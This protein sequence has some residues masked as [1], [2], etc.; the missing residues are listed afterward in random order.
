M[1]VFAA[2][3]AAMAGRMRREISPTPPASAAIAIVITVLAHVALGFLFIGG[4]DEVGRML[5]SAG[6][7]LLAAPCALLCSAAAF[8]GMHFTLRRRFGG[9]R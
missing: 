2:A 3:M 7:M 9:T 1:L 6:C 4:G 8:L 5:L